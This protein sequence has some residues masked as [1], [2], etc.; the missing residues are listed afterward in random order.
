MQTL[1]GQIGGEAAVTAAVRIFYRKVMEDDLIRP[2]FSDLDMEAQTR[3][4]VAF[5]T[6]A[7][8]GPSAYRGRDLR[9]AHASLVKERG[10]SDIHFDAVARHLDATLTEL[11]VPD[12]LRNEAMRR[13]AALRQ[14]VLNR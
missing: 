3:K 14:E 5:M 10:L 11:A 4:Q 9:T 7:F 12:E 6:W 1:Y 8:D 13:V 2:F